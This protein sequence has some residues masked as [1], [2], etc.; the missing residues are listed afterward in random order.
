M[1][2]PPKPKGPSDTEIVAAWR[3]L[4]T[5]MPGIS[6]E[7]LLL[8]VAEKLSIKPDR[9]MDALEREAEKADAFPRAGLFLEVAGQLERMEQPLNMLWMQQSNVTL[10]ELRAVSAKIAQLLRSKYG[11]DGVG[12]SPESLVVGPSETV[13]GQRHAAASETVEE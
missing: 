5:S 8:G 10:E 4:E 13:L 12:A 2:R 7:L 6:T 3:D 1:K 9:I 11:A